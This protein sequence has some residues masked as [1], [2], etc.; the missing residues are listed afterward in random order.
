MHHIYAN[1]LL[2]ISA[3]GAPN[4]NAGLFGC[5]DP[6]LSCKLIAKLKHPRRNVVLIPEPNILAATIIGG[7]LAK[8]GWVLQEQLLARRVLYFGEQLFWECAENWACETLPE[9]P[10]GM[11][12]LLGTPTCFAT[13]RRITAIVSEQFHCTSWF[14]QTSLYA[15]WDSIC[16]EYSRRL[17]TRQSDKAIAISGIAEYFKALLSE[18]YIA[19]IWKGDLIPGLLRFIEISGD[20]QT[21]KDI[22]PSW[23]WLSPKAEIA[24]ASKDRR[25]GHYVASVRRV[26]MT[27]PTDGAGGPRTKNIYITLF[28]VLR[29]FQWRYSDSNEHPQDSGDLYF[30]GS[31]AIPSIG[32]QR[33][34]AH[35]IIRL[36]SGE[37]VESSQLYMCPLIFSE[38]QDTRQRKL[39]GLLLS[40]LYDDSGDIYLRVGYFKTTAF[41]QMFY[42]MLSP[43]LRKIDGDPWDY[44]EKTFGPDEAA[45]RNNDLWDLFSSD[46]EGLGQTNDFAPHM[47]LQQW[48]TPPLDEV[49]EPLHRQTIVII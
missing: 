39:E 44:F 28:G 41:A 45:K 10:T 30:D 36:D 16:M 40:R 13:Q 42:R 37:N 46:Q 23:S 3:S 1:A 33:Q 19:G 27:A 8:R 22:A 15:V 32:R 38:D 47:R 17:L 9:G 24:Y 43:T 7:P 12:S 20:R 49:F 21:L 11:L 48:L 29:P 4:S 34:T 35:G 5:R 31:I 25:F 14:R 18:E 2:N 6:G 26:S